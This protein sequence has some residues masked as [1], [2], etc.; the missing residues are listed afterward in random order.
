MGYFVKFAA[1]GL[2]C[3]FLIPPNVVHNSEHA[4]LC[5][6]QFLFYFLYQRP[7]GALIEENVFYGCTEQL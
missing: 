7:G 3:D 5:S 2:I 1:E 4:S 6:V